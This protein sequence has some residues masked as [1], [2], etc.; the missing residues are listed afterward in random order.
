MSTVK[1]TS[2]TF[3]P[4]LKHCC[5]SFLSLT[6]FKPCFGCEIGMV[7]MSSETFAHS[8]QSYVYESYIFN[9]LTLIEWVVSGQTE[10]FGY[11]VILNICKSL[12]LTHFFWLIPEI[13]P[14]RI[15][16]FGANMKHCTELQGFSLYKNKFN[17]KLV[18]RLKWKIAINSNLTSNCIM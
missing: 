12:L 10:F 8:F 18:L 1:N 17:V 16:G 7:Y 5:S 9:H 13:F 3:V 11:K 4:G 14:R 6:T 2:E 15:V